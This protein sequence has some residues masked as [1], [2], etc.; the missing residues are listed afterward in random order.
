[1]GQVSI[2]T[3]EREVFR[4]PVIVASKNRQSN[5]YKACKFKASVLSLLLFFSCE[6]LPIAAKDH[7]R[8]TLWV[9]ACID[10]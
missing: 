5:E 10:I 6:F 2:F 7:I 3:S 4:R 8:L 1:M 9:L